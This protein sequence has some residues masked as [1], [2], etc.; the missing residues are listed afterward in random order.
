LPQGLWSPQRSHLLDAVYDYLRAEQRKSQALF[1]VVITSIFNCFAARVSQGAAR[2]GESQAHVNTALQRLIARVILARSQNKLRRPTEGG[3]TETIFAALRF[4]AAVAV[5]D[6]TITIIP[7]FQRNQ[8]QFLIFDFLNFDC[9]SGTFDQAFEV[10]F[11]SLG[12]IINSKICSF[13]LL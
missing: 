5:A 4:V 6:Q 1:G 8:L 3:D 13:Y 7:A 12:T 2:H 10:F 11:S 9:R